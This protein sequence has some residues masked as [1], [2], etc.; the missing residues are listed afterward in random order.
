MNPLFG[1]LRHIHFVGIGGVGMSGIAEVLVNLGHRVS[2]SDIVESEATQRLVGLGA[3]VH[4]GHHATAVSADVD[5]VVMSSAAKFAN[6]E[7]LRA[8]ELGIPV[9]PRAEM[10]AELMRMKTGIAVAGTHGKTTTTSMIATVLHH[11]GLDPTAVIGGRL[12]AYGTNAQ[13]GRSDLMVVEADESD[14]TFLLLSPTIAVVTNV[15]REHLDHYGSVEGM[16]AAFAD[17]INRVPFFGVAVVCLDDLAIRGM[18]P[19]LRKPVVTYGTSPEADYVVRDIRVV[20]MHTRATVERRGDTPVEIVVPMPGR[21]QAMNAV[22]TF[23]VARHLGASA[24]K[25]LEALAGFGGIHRRF[26][27]CGEVDGVTVVSDYAHHPTEIRATIEAAREGFD[28]RIVAA[29]QPHRYSR[30]KDLFDEF[31]GAFDAADRVVVTEV[32][33]AGEDPIEG[34]TGEALYTALKR[35]GHLDVA[36]AADEEILLDVLVADAL[37]GDL[38][39]ILGAGSIYRLAPRLVDALQMRAAAR[40]AEVAERR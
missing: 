1:A 9:I 35:R 27:I 2:G 39:L 19:Q 17:F 40:A 15:E 3:T 37:P 6:P 21:H 34:A 24:D 16:R 14:G 30:L 18:L 33:P 36:V 29:F 32:Y 28:R 8:R 12:L 13:L 20:G 31:L 7:V 26:E 11:A 4:Y 23:A 38:V 22:A 25:V 5:V 10:L